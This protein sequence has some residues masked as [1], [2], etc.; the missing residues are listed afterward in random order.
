MDPQTPSITTLTVDWNSPSDLK[1]AIST[2][3]KRRKSV[4]RQLGFRGIQF[5]GSR[6]N[7][8]TIYPIF[9]DILATDLSSVF[10]NCDPE[11]KYYV[12][13]HCR[14]DRPLNVQGNLKHFFLATQ[15]KLTHE[16][17]YV[18]KG[19]GERSLDLQRNDSHRKI[20]TSLL[21]RGLDFQT[22]RV[23]EQLTEAEALSLESKLIDM[24]GIHCLSPH[25]MLVNLDE[26]RAAAE[27]RRL[28]SHDL[29]LDLLKK[30]GFM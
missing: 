17:S 6:V 28:Y 26:G 1:K 14:P 20:R 4:L 25:G 15:F 23:A 10:P 11:P 16:P 9:Q 7:C 29:I 18:G 24:L 22:V 27:R 3:Q 21:K 2:L 12:Y 8:D 13:V 19:T 30:N 5:N